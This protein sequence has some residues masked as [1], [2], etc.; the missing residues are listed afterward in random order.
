MPI[1][2]KISLA[3]LAQN[4]QDRT[5]VPNWPKDQC[6]VMPIRG[7]KIFVYLFVINYI[8]ETWIKE[9]NEKALN[10][11]KHNSRISFLFHNLSPKN[12]HISKLDFDP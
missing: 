4:P 11:H 12:A 2:G 9:I 5:C 7:M 10:D 8:I 3:Q 1:F 6:S